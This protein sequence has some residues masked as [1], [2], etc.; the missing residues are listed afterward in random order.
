MEM[1]WLGG[2]SGG[3]GRICGQWGWRVGEE[4]G[5][6]GS[7][8]FLCI[9]ASLFRNVSPET[10]RKTGNVETETENKRGTRDSMISSNTEQKHTMW[11]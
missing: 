5:G 4:G 3:C 1:P 8:S 11:P 2:S 7:V 9:M 10:H 6:E